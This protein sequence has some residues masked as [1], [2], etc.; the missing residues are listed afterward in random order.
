MKFNIKLTKNN[1]VILSTIA[2]TI[3]ILLH[4][5]A[6][7]YQDKSD[8]SFVRRDDA[9]KV[10]DFKAMEKQTN[11]ILYHLTNKS[12]QTYKENA[13]K[14]EKSA[15]EAFQKWDKFFADFVYYQ[16]LEYVFSSAE[17]VF[18]LISIFLN[19]KALR[20]E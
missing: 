16:K 10:L 18:I 3:A 5:I 13:E 19:V 9:I 8:F 1:C 7:N 12:N 6:D 20:K 17:L 14:T 2:I 11:L 4:F 15:R